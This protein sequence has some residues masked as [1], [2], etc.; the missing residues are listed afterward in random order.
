MQVKKSK[1]L[2]H[3]TLVYPNGLTRTVPVRAVTREVAEKRALKRNP[4]A[5][6][7]KYDG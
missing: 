3:I 1:L 5:T 2:Y 7:V 4:G 6:G